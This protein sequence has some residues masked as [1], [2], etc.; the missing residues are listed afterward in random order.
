MPGVLVLKVARDSPAARAG[1]RATKQCVIRGPSGVAHTRLRGYTSC[2]LRWAVATMACGAQIEAVVQ[3]KD[4]TQSIRIQAVEAP[5]VYGRSRAAHTQAMKRRSPSQGG[6]VVLGDLVVAVDQKP[7]GTVAEL[8]AALG[9][10][11]PEGYSLPLRPLRLSRREGDDLRLHEHRASAQLTS[12]PTND[13][14]TRWPFLAVHVD[15]SGR[16]AQV[17]CGAAHAA[18][19]LP[20]G[21]RRLTS[22]FLLLTSFFLLPTLL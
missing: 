2:L 4:L 8:L 5:A 15:V 22:Y 17:W 14:S 3:T 21:L 6:A 19:C 16:D 9:E 7:V 12:L 1:I 18:V 10:A 20:R 13:R 11:G